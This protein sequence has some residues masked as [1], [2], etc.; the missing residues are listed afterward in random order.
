M[1]FYP[2]FTLAVK[3]ALLP[4]SQVVE[5]GSVMPTRFSN[6]YKCTKI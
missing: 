1:G 4:L 6:T 5:N 3:N 2:G